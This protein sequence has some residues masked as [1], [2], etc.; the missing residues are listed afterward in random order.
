MAEQQANI[1]LSVIVPCYNVEKYLDKSLQCLEK[2]W[3]ERT[4]YEIILVNDASKDGTLNKLKDFIA[5]HPDHT[6]LIDKQQN[7][8][9]AAARNSAMDIAR[10][11]WIA[12]FD[13]DDM[14]AEG[15]YDK[16]L[17]LTRE[18]DGYD[19]IRF[20]VKIVNN[21][22]DVTA[23]LS[24]P[25]TVDWKGTTLEYMQENTYGTC[26]C[27]IYRREMLEGRRF[28]RNVIV[29]DLLFLVPILLEGKKIM[30]TDATVYYYYVRANA[31][32]SVAH[33]VNRLSL[34]SDDI[35]TAVEILEGYKQGQP[36]AIQQRLLEKQQ[37]LVRNM[38]IRMLL[39]NK[40]SRN[41]NQI[42]QSMKALN[43]FPIPESETKIRFVNFVFKNL[44]ALPVSRPMYR[45]FNRI[46]PKI[47]RLKR[48][49]A[50]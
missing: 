18:A 39:S 4:D 29:E 33:D 25:L 12:F 45:L 30:K 50:K 28:P 19:M 31:A 10:G 6:K 21:D 44:W 49:L 7:G 2:Q 5:R 43:L 1:S 20:G 46:Y 9:L 42:V 41:V 47:R 24:E 26:W 8:G 3:G 15:S 13:P 38:S 34:Q 37:F 16:L 32:T 23:V 40:S 17:D 11:Q 36:E 35:A 48:R 14:L 27:Y 22:E